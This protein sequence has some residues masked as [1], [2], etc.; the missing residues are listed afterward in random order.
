MNARLP[1]GSYLTVEWPTNFGGK[2]DYCPD[3]NPDEL[4]AKALELQDKFYY[5]SH[6]WDHP[7]NLDDLDNATAY[8]EMYEEVSKNI[9]FLST[10]FAGGLSR[11]SN[12]SMIT[13]CVTGMQR[14]ISTQ[15]PFLT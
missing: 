13:P 14:Q 9:N 12:S 8:S 11:W 5:L 15:S 7:C 10:F 4:Y 2:D 6:T 3:C 1:E